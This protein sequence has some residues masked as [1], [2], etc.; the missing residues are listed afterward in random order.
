MA[1]PAEFT[2]A[3]LTEVSDTIKVVD[4]IAIMLRPAATFITDAAQGRVVVCG[5][6][7]FTIS[8]THLSAVSGFSTRSQIAGRPLVNHTKTLVT[9]VVLEGL[10]QTSVTVATEQLIEVQPQQVLVTAVW[11]LVAYPV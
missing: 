9:K 3:A 4:Q 11:T 8:L 1:T 10:G 5:T 2:M 6:I 7:Q